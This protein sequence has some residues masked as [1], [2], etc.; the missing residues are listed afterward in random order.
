[1]KVPKHRT[2]IRRMW[3]AR[4]NKLTA[5]GPVLAA[6]L[7]WNGKRC[8]RPGCRCERGEKHMAYYLTYK[9]HGKTRTVYVPVDLVKEVRRWIKEHQRLKQL[10]RELS[11][12]S[13]AMVKTHVRARKRKAGRS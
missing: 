11:Q 12:L 9:E 13:I 3:L 10:S 4:V 5:Q 7:V 2:L 6:S 8:G 1:M